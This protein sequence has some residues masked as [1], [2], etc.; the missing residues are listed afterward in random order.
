VVG[1]VLYTTAGTRRA[2]LALN[3]ATGEVLWMHTEDE[4][5]RGQNAARSG[6]G[7]GVSYWSSADGVDQRIIYV[8]PGYR[9]IA[10]NART[11]IPIPTF[12]RDGVVDL[13]LEND[14]DLDPSPPISD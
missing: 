1:N 10:L 6:A 2:V 11:G 12:G 8:T 14:Q 9:M 13:K 7:R 3:A 4:G 5:A